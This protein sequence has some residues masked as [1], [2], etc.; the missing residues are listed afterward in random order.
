METNRN[1]ID[2]ETIR[3]FVVLGLLTLALVLGL[4]WTLFAPPNAEVSGSL[5]QLKAERP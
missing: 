3:L 1:N 2:P 5:Q 4:R